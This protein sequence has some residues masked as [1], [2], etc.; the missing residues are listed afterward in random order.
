[1]SGRTTG[2]AA[3]ALAVG[4]VACA[5]VPYTHRS[6]L[7]LVSSSEEAQLGAQ[8]FAGVLKE[9]N[10]DSSPAVN[11]PVLEVG[12]RIAG[13]AD[14]PDFRWQFVV[15]DDTRTVNAFCLPGGKVAVYTGILPVVQDTNGLAVVLGHEIAHA[16]ARHGAERMSQQEVVSAVGTAIGIAGG[17]N[18]GLLLAA[19]GA[20][21]QL[22]VLL[23]YSRA[24][25]SEADHIG[26]ILMAKAGYDP[27]GAL[28]FWRRMESRGG[29]QPPEFLSTH[30]GHGTR[31]TQ[32]A[33][34]MPEAL[35]YYERADHAPVTSIP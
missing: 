23:P 12:R 4:L 13:V 1:M 29:K 14:R 35:Q 3:F 21:A 22:G 17:Q 26:L 33:Q 7:I 30:P 15:I 31:E 5:T 16:V 18:A 10:V 24:H 6:Q 27:R 20:G 28:E 8:A 2:A 34:W 11:A 32:L 19:Y 9:S 25:E